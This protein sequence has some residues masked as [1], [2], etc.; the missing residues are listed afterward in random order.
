VTQLKSHDEVDA[1][2]LSRI[3]G[4]IKIAERAVLTVDAVLCAHTFVGMKQ[5]DKGEVAQ[6][7]VVYLQS[8]PPEVKCSPLFVIKSK[9]G[10]VDDDIQCEIDEVFEIARRSTSRL[11]I[12][13]DGDSS[14]NGRHSSFMEFWE[15]IYRASGLD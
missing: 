14:S 7:F 13:S 11:F 10:M 2:L 9:S 3:A 6:F 8:L 1:Y 5:V 12:S 15:P 4:H